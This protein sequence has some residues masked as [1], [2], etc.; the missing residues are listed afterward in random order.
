MKVG[1]QIPRFTWPHG[2]A[3]IGPRLRRIARTAEAAKFD[4]LWL[5]DHYFQ[6]PG[7]GQAE[8]PMLE[9]YSGLSHLA[10]VTEEIKLGTMVSGVI[11]RQPAFLVKQVTTLDV[12]SNGRA[13]FGVGAGWFERE[14]RGLGFRFATV[15]ERFER[16]EETLQIAGQMWSDDNGTFRGEHYQLEETLC[17]PQP[18]TQP[19]PPILIGGM[20]ERKTLRLVAQYADACNLFMRA[21]RETLRHKLDVLAEHCQDI[22]RNYE[23][24]EKTVLG[25]VHLAEGE[26]SA[27]S[28][29]D[30]LG[31]MAQLGFDHVIFNMPNVHELTPLQRFGREVIPQARGL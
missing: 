8:E 11:Y 6:I 18:L 26:M 20:G 28:V 3:G 1:L 15:S 31:V 7:V 4:S 22:G 2:D 13:Y 12:L 23:S 25:T 5:M 30:R 9:G 16:L 21:G 14:A 10:A 27:S 24:I 19:R 17:R 29:V